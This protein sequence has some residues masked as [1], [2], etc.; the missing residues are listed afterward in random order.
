V[1]KIDYSVRGLGWSLVTAIVIQLLFVVGLHFFGLAGLDWKTAFVSGPMAVG[2]LFLI[3]FGFISSGEISWSKQG[4]DFSVLA[5]GAI[6]STLT[7]QFF[8]KT[9]ALPVLA[10]GRVGT[11]LSGLLGGERV[12][13]FALLAL[14][15][16]VSMLVC[17]LT[18]AIELHLKAVHSAGGTAGR[19]DNGFAFLNY[20]LGLFS[21]LIYT[22]IVCGGIEI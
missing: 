15:L 10:H 20:V 16:L 9:P 7:L 1:P 22:V 11:F 14:G 13:M 3:F 21:L 19:A 4:F 18:A 8:M 6:L 2:V 17:G 5:F 12:T